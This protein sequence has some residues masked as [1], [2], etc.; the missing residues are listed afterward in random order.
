MAGPGQLLGRG[1]ARRPGADDGHRLA[2]DEVRRVGPHPALVE[3]IVDDLDLDL[4][5]GHRVLVDA[6]DTGGPRT[7][8]GTADR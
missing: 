2:G 6:Q 5:D 4:L 3:G 7:A 1:Q 8:P